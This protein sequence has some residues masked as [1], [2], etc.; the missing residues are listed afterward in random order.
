MPKPPFGGLANIPGGAELMYL[1]VISFP[2]LHPIW[3]PRMGRAD[4]CLR[5]ERR[6]LASTKENL[7]IVQI[8]SPARGTVAACSVMARA[9]RS[10][11][12]VVLAFGTCSIV[13]T[14]RVGCRRSKR[15][16]AWRC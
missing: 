1:T 11:A 7:A 13:T 12:M 3:Q 6:A 8:T 14:G 10:I 16:S 4:A 2:H 5:S 9:A 15:G